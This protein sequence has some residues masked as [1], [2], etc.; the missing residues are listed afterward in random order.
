MP[1]DSPRLSTDSRRPSFGFGRKT[2]DLRKNSDVSKQEK[3]RRFSLL[4]ASFSFRGLT[5][6]AKDQSSDTSLPASEQRP[7]TMPQAPPSRGHPRSEPSAY[8]YRNEAGA[9]TG[10]DGQ[11]DSDGAQTRRTNNPSSRG[12]PQMQQPYNPD[13]QPPI[14]PDPLGPPRPPQG[15]SYLLGESGSPSESEISVN[16][17]Q[18]RPMYPPG[19]NSYEDDAR[20]SM[21]PR[22]AAVLQKNNRRFADAYEQDQEPGYGGGG[23]NAG[24]SGAAKRVM[25]FFRRRGK[26]RGG[27]DRV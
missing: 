15:Q 12:A 3:P 26:A 6:A 8:N 14:L 20:Q 25:D 21:N 7:S 2:S 18:R 1:S 16:A 17:A 27:E 19:F 5:G 24:S 13:S 22:G 10:Y 23:R 4:P 11:R 9:P